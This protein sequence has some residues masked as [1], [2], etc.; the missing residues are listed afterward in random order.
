[1]GEFD[2]KFARLKIILI[3][4]TFLS[5]MVTCEFVFFGSNSN[6]DTIDISN[7]EQ[8]EKPTDIWSG[9][10]S[11]FSGI[12]NFFTLAFQFLTFTLPQIPIWMTVIMGIPMAIMTITEIYLVVDIVYSFVKALP[13]T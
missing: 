8:T 6:P 5:F 4:F 3:I 7:I 12:V 9:I 13:F 11:V 1:M 10:G 2:E